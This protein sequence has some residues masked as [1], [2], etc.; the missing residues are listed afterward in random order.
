[1]T[2]ITPTQL[3]KILA[4]G[5]DIIVID[6]RDP[7]EWEDLRIN[8][9]RV[10]NIPLGIFKTKIDIIDKSKSIYVMC[11][12]GVRSQTAQSILSSNGIQSTNVEGGMNLWYSYKLPLEYKV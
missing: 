11:A 2:Q 9:K 4:S 3:D 12:S 7:D 8:D 10:I 6:V 5:E 1:M